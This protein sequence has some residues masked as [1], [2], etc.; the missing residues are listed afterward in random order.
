MQQTKLTLKSKVIITPIGQMVAIGNNEHLYLLE[1][2]DRVTLKRQIDTL[3]SSSGSDLLPGNSNTITSVEKELKLYFN[4]DLR[5][6]KTPIKMYGTEFRKIVWN[7][8]LTIPCGETRSYK[9]LAISIDNPKCVR[10]LAGA[11]GAN[12]FSL[13]VPC[14]RVIS[15]DGTI[16]GYSGG[17]HHKEK[18]LE[19]ERN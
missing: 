12:R 2:A 10:A 8:L 3:L 4:K 6:F 11:C 13:I 1:F 9:D 16:G 14:H 15:S 7:A 17:L 5:E 18:L 19:L